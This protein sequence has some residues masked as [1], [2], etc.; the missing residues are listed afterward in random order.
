[1]TNYLGK[2]VQYLRKEAKLSQQALA[3]KVGLTRSNIASYENGKAEPR[4]IKLAELARFFNVSLGQLIEADLQKMPHDHI[5]PALP[6]AD[7]TPGNSD[8]ART[9]LRFDEKSTK[10]KKILE[11]LRA[12]YELK[13]NEDGGHA[14]TSPE[15]QTLVR[16][17][18][19]LLNVMTN[20]VESNEEIIAYLKSIRH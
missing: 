6:L 3:E 2:N 14:D 20:L 1:M 9:I 17:F 11:G 10:L 13:L 4:A 18:E 19:N 12:F 15:M 16:D 7:G 5:Q 8:S